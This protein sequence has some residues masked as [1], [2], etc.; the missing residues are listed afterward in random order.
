MTMRRL[1]AAVGVLLLSALAAPAA[2]LPLQKFASPS[3]RFS[4]LLP[5]APAI[6]SRAM[7][8]G[9]GAD[10]TK[11]YQFYT[12]ADSVAYIVM[13]NDFPPG[14]ITVPPDV[15]LK[16]AGAGAIKKRTL[17][18]DRMVTLHGVPG[19]AI[20][21]TDEHAIY[22]IHDY[23]IANRLYELVVRVPRGSHPAYLNAV[24]NSFTILK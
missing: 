19:I 22:D 24:V 14:D 21:A 13:Y 5:G 10:Q 12:E 6:S 9:H 11:V 16:R 15:F 8:T 1:F 3:G 20:V 7:L 18:T 2:D 23:L 17:V 4:V